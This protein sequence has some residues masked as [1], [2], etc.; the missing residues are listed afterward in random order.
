[1]G[2]GNKIYGERERKIISTS[3]CGTFFGSLLGNDLLYIGENYV[4]LIRKK[5]SSSLKKKRFFDYEMIT[6]AFSCRGLKI[7]LI[8]IT[9]S[10][11]SKEEKKAQE[12]L[13][14]KWMINFIQWPFLWPWYWKQNMILFS[15]CSGSMLFDRIVSNCI[16]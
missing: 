2:N 4:T 15:L 10:S 3:W 1:M 8:H 5:K 7:K 13:A 14:W 16:F 12:I 11:F 6:H 9:R